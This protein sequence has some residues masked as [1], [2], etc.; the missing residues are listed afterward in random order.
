MSDTLCSLS[1]RALARLAAASLA[2]CALGATPLSAQDAD[3]GFEAALDRAKVLEQRNPL[4][5]HI[6]AWELLAGTRDARGIQE[7]HQRYSKPK[8]PKEPYRYLVA[9]AATKGFDDATMA[10][11]DEWREDAKDPEDA[12]LWYLALGAHAAAKDFEPIAAIA[13]TNPSVYL[14]AAA[15]EAL[16]AAKA[17]E[18]GAVVIE[19]AAAMPK[20]PGEKALL[21]GAFSTAILKTANKKTR[22]ESDWQRMALAVVAQFDDES[23]PR[24][25]RLALAR[26]LAKALDADTV[27]LEAHYW[28]GE[29]SSEVAEKKAKDAKKKGKEVNYV[30]PRFFGVE[31]SGERIAYVIDLSDSMLEPIEGLAEKQKGP[32]SGPKPKREK[33][34]LPTEADIPWQLVKTRFDLAREHIKI[35]LQRLSDEQYFTV[36][37]FGSSAELLDGLPGLVKASKGNVK[38]AIQALDSIRIGGPQHGKPHGVLYGNT[39]LHA[40]IRLAFR[41]RE[42]GAVEEF[43]H[44]DLSGFDEGCDTIFVLSDGDPSFDDYETEDADFGDGNVVTDQESKEKAN[45]TPRL[46]YPGPYAMWNHLLEDVRRMNLFR[47]VEIHCISIGETQQGWLQKLADIGLGQVADGTK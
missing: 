30:K 19:Q 42:R 13:R 46:R 32:K 16:A 29:L 10:A 40:G 35:S 2:C 44:V 1:P 6:E 4:R 36:V 26:H 27:A 12:W 28:R 37:T 3:A 8:N 7:L 17:P 25:A 23:I 9:L 47:E 41:V 31:A 24:P 14:R 18:L 5:Y 20:K 33:G 21:L 15:I 43:E 22:T 38:K 11:L 39:N 45:R 34:D